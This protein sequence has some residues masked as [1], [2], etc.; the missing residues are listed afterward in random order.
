VSDYK[1]DLW[2]E[3]ARND[4]PMAKAIALTNKAF[5]GCRLHTFRWLKEPKHV[6]CVQRRAPKQAVEV[7]VE[8]DE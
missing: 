3:I 2:E 8:D 7:T 4:P 1:K 5:G 6:F